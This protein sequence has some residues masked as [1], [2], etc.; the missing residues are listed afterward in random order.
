MLGHYSSVNETAG[1]SPRLNRKALANATSPPI[2][3]IS[4]AA[5]TEARSPAIAITVVSPCIA[6]DDHR[7]LRGL[8]FPLDR[9]EW[10]AA[11]L[12]V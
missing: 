10:W 3:L 11:K 5:V 2:M 8:F 6:V 12:R 4:P 7:L 1:N 9:R